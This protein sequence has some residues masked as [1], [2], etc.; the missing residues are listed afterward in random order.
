VRL[1][2]LLNIV[3]FI[4]WSMFDLVVMRDRHCTAMR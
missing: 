3:Q 4:G 1:P 2:V